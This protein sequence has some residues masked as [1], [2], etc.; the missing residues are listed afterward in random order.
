MKKKSRGRKWLFALSAMA[1]LAVLAVVLAPRFVVQ[2]ATQKPENS[3]TFVTRQIE[4]ENLQ[5]KM[6]AALQN[7]DQPAE[8]QPVTPN[9]QPDGQS[10]Q[11]HSTQTEHT[12]PAATD[13]ITPEDTS[14]EPQAGLPNNAPDTRTSTPAAGAPTTPVQPPANRPRQIQLRMS[15]QEVSSMIYNGLYQGTAPEYQASIQGVSTQIAG[16][17]ATVTVALNPK[18]L[19]DGFIKNIP[20]VG[21]STSTV[22]LGGSMSL[23][24]DGNSVSPVIHH[25]SL[26]KFKVPMPFLQ[27]AVKSQVQAYVQNMMRLPNGQQAYLDQVELENGAVTLTVHTN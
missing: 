13:P 21:R 15:E 27:S 5:Q 6:Q 18:Y 22:Y 11:A 25:M 16:G 4:S 9:S 7:P 19:P 23:Q 2:Q 17:K 10:A 20:G 3:G 24:K 8:A 26:G 14:T 1:L 12:G